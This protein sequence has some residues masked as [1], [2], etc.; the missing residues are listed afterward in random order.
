MINNYLE[1]R[2]SDS[3]GRTSLPFPVTVSTIAELSEKIETL[4]P[5]SKVEP[6]GRDLTVEDVDKVCGGM[7]LRNQPLDMSWG[8]GEEQEIGS[9]E[10]E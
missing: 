10:E 7:G 5:I 2:D 1:C 6:A 8:V 3:E 9:I 4:L